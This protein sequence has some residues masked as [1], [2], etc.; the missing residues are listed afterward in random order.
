[1]SLSLSLCCRNYPPLWPDLLQPHWGP[2]SG[3]SECVDRRY[4]GPSYNVLLQQLTVKYK[5]CQHCQLYLSLSP[6]QDSIISPPTIKT[7]LFTDC[8]SSG[9]QEFRSSFHVLPVFLSKAV[10]TYNDQ[11]DISINN[12]LTIS[13][14]QKDQIIKCLSVWLAPCIKNIYIF[15]RL[16]ISLCQYSESRTLYLYLE[17]IGDEWWIKGKRQTYHIPRPNYIMLQYNNTYNITT[18]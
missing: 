6:V 16:T 7:T 1:M 11:F 10:V 9:G 15:S 2:H 4:V 13:Y 17:N 8:E 3:R 5:P 12:K 14:Q 18:I